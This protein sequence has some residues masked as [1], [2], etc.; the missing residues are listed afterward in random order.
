M[1][2]PT[3]MTDANHIG[4]DT[5]NNANGAPVALITGGAVRVGR[6][7]AMALA[8][9]GY[10]VLIHYRRSAT[11]AEKTKALVESKGRRSAT[12]Q[13]DL[14]DDETPAKLIDCAQQSFGRL[15][16]LIN[17]AS[18]F[19]PDS[20]DAFSGERWRQM[21]QVNAIAPAAL[22]DAAI[23]LLENSNCGQAINLCD[24]SADRPWPTHRAYCA[25][26]A[27]LAN[28]TVSYARRLAPNV[29]VNGVAPGIAIFPDDYDEPTR[30]RLVAK[31]PLRREG[32]VE[33]IARTVRFLAEH[34]DYITGQIIRVDGGR[35][36]V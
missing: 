2:M 25:S 3:M 19:E 22:I 34:G 1:K 12:I 5:P 28:L 24:I 16:L 10:D 13:G 18:Q 15:D 36:I 29:R 30:Q 8:D 4:D 17:N 23:P 33:D 11:D 6:G 7:I 35:S 26:K 21:F 32:T 14:V 20:M 27:A 31:V 9:A